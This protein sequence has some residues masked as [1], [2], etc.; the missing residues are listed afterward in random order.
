MV[1]GAAL[2]LVFAFVYNPRYGLLNSL[3]APLG[4]VE[5]DRDWL[6]DLTTALPAVAGTYVFL[7][8]MFVVLI[9]TEILSMPQ[10]VQEAAT[11]DGAS[12]FQR[13]LRITVPL[14]RQVLGTCVLLGVLA[15][16]AFF[17]T[18]Y[19]LTAG[20]PGDA[21]ITLG[22]YTFRAYNEGT[23]GM[24]NAAGTLMIVAGVMVILVVRRVFRFGEGD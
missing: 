6:F 22:L 8:G 23:W 19:V 10:E 12:T 21:T 4:L 20:G 5:P 16:V 13:H 15:S 18:V 2:G 14:L 1:S 24:A 9:L 3:L 7:I 17:D 11:V